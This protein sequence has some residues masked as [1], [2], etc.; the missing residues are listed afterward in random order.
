MCRCWDRNQSK[1]DRRRRNGAARSHLS[2]YPEDSRRRLVAG[3]LTAQGR[4]QRRIAQGV[5]SASVDD[6]GDGNSSDQRVHLQQPAAGA[7]GGY[8]QKAAGQRL[9]GIGDP[10]PV[11]R[12]VDLDVLRLP[13]PAIPSTPS[14][15]CS[16]A[17]STSGILTSLC[18]TSPTCSRRMPTQGN[19]CTPVAPSTCITVSWFRCSF[20]S[21]TR[22][23]EIME[24]SAPAVQQKPERSFAIEHDRRDHPPT[25]I[26]LRR[27]GELGTGRAR[28]RNGHR[29]LGSSPTALESE[30]LPGAPAGRSTSKAVSPN[31]I[32]WMDLMAT[33]REISG[34][35][36]TA[37]L[38]DQGASPRHLS[39][40]K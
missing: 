10:D 33:S 36:A 13:A 34:A 8:G 32:Q 20:K 37:P 27:T 6:G 2:G 17:P 18:T 25:A 15:P 22:R 24:P 4:A 5:G 7:Q 40:S 35:G 3:D 26:R 38:Y 9:L 30:A 16:T 11:V 23:G 31:T 1:R 29:G 39:A 14:S 28:L 12:E 21:G 19:S